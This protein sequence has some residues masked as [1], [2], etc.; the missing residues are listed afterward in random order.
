MKV[1][2]SSDFA[3]EYTVLLDRVT[4]LYEFEGDGE[5]GEP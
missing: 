3:D 1:V 2:V 5:G 4:V